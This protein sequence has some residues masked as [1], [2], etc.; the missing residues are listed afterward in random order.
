MAIICWTVEI[1]NHV[2]NNSDIISNPL[3]NYNNSIQYI[4]N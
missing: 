1:S 3:K 4:N 2:E